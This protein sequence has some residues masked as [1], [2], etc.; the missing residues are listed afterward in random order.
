MET[1]YYYQYLY[2]SFENWLHDAEPEWKKNHFVIFI[3]E[4]LSGE[5][6]HDVFIL[7]ML[8]IHN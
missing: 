7:P 8:F 2:P 6:L 5:L 1:P 3:L 4:R